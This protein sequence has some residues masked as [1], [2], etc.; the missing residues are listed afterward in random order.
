MLFHN[1]LEFQRKLIKFMIFTHR[2]RNE[3]YDYVCKN[4]NYC[5]FRLTDENFKTKHPDEMQELYEFW[6]SMKTLMDVDF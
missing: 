2:G 3:A 5:Q 1:D 6:D 4:R